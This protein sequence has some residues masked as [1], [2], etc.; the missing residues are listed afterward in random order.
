MRSLSSF[1]AVVGAGAG[2]A[3]AGTA[4]TAGSGNRATARTRP[5]HRA[6]RT[7]SATA[8]ARCP[9]PV[10]VTA[11]Q[12]VASR[13]LGAID[14]ISPTVG[15]A[16]TASQILCELPVRGGFEG[17]SQ[18][19]TV[20]LAVSRD[21]GRTWVAQGTALPAPPRNGFFEQRVAATSLE[22]L[23]A[24][25]GA[26]PLLATTTGGR[27]WTV[28]PVSGPVVAVEISGPTLWALACPPI[29][30]VSCRPVLERKRVAGGAWRRLPLPKLESDPDPTLAPASAT[31][32]LV[33]VLRPGANGGTLVESSDG[34]RHWTRRPE[35]RWL[36]RPCWGA[37]FI[38]AGPRDWWLICLGGAAA[39]SS[40]K[41]LL[42]TTDAGA[43]WQVASQITSLTLPVRPGAIPLAE[44]D[45]LAAASP[46]RLWFAGQNSLYD[47]DDG[48]IRW[49]S[50]P[51]PNPQGSPASFDVLSPTRAWL[52]A[53]GQGLWRTTDGDRWHA[54]G[55]TFWP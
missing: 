13:Q 40:T 46:T 16:L 21:G 19:Q 27:Q 24:S 23:W 4:L 22:N 37:G 30:D 1:L 52:L 28:Q 15:V 35:P 12:R 8:T 36:G 51:G 34:G 54:M 17:Y 50:A 49:T 41:A 10:Q 39:G 45:A 7:A 43:S 14:F 18:R 42:H 55:P 31:T 5:N 26:G 38:T 9:Q 44:P 20:L 25:S 6:A 32:V 2:V 29:V 53:P 11:G 47:S 3:L 33:H 48:G